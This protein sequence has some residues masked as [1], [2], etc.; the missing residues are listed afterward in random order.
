MVRSSLFG[1]CPNCVFGHL[2]D[3]PFRAHKHCASCGMCLEPDGSNGLG[4]GFV[5]YVLALF[6]LGFEGVALGLLFGLFPGFAWVLALSAVLLVVL[7]YRPVR[8][9]WVWLLWTLGELE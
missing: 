8:G 4:T 2:F 3:G 1:E 5:V 9:W 7:L 6:L